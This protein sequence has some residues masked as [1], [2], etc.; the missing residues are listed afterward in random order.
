[1]AWLCLCD[2][3]NH[4]EALSHN[5]LQGAV[6]SCGCLQRETGTINGLKHG[7]HNTRLYRVWA[8]VKVR[9]YSKS[10]PTYKNYG[11]R[12]IGMCSDWRNNFQSFYDWA[13]ANGYDET[14]DRYAC[15]LD[16][17]DVNGDYGPDNCRWVTQKQ[18]CNNTRHNLTVT[19]DGTT[20]T[21]AEWCDDSGVNRS[22]AYSRIRNGWQ[23]ERAV[24]TP[25]RPKRKK[26]HAA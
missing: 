11:A 25:S 6:K 20:K 3:G 14:A 16:R 22:T 5:L 1:M 7:M 24:L 15:T 19:I 12:G 10:H 8:A 4:H 17:I 21:V 9:C 26:G 18:Q 23:P 2:C 13:M